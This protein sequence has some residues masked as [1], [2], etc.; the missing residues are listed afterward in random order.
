[1][2]KKKKRRRIKKKSYLNRYAVILFTIFIINIILLVCAIFYAF[3]KNKEEA[4]IN[5]DLSSFS[6][7]VPNILY[8][9]KLN[10]LEILNLFLKDDK[11][12]YGKV[13]IKVMVMK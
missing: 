5:Q 10:D 2:A 6:S 3:N 12:L 11:K 13:N 4:I 8:D 9:T 1:M 7:K